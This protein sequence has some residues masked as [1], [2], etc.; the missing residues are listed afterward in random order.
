[1]GLAKLHGYL[2]D[3]TEDVTK[4]QDMTQAERTAELER[5]QAELDALA[6]PKVVA[7]SG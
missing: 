2:V 6:G 4:V 1:M 5:V 3:R 7:I